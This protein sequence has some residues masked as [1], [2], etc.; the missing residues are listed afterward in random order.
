MPAPAL[1]AAACR[2]CLQAVAKLTAR[3]PYTSTRIGVRV[4]LEITVTVSLNS[5]LP[6]YLVP[7]LRVIPPPCSDRVMLSRLQCAHGSVLILYVVLEFPLESVPRRLQ[8]RR[9]VLKMQVSGWS[10]DQCEGLG[11]VGQHE[12]TF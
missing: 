4:H 6:D 2:C 3:G 10:R 11:S 12:A 9:V 7:S 8:L 1:R 5:R